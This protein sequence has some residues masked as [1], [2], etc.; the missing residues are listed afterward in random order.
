MINSI[1]L[2]VFDEKK[3]YLYTMIFP[4]VICF[5]LL[6]LIA[7]LS[8]INFRNFRKDGASQYLEKQMPD[9][10]KRLHPWGN[11]SHNG[12]AYISFLRGKYD[13]GSDQKLNIIKRNEKENVLFLLWVLLLT[14]LSWGV[15]V[16][17]IF[18]KRFMA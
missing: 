2:F 7:I 1:L 10:W 5:I 4:F 15:N 3:F 17:I 16:S 13:N 12:F 18:L 9:L 8:V 11:Y 14:P 6:I